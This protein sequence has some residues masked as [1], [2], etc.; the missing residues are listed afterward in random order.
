MAYGKAIV[1]T[2]VAFEG[3]DTSLGLISESTA[4]GFAEQTL[5][6]IRDDNYR[7][8]QEKIA[9]RSFEHQHSYKSLVKKINDEILYDMA[10]EQ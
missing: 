6:L 10:S 2:P 7:K 9:A 5:N 8:N 1:G 4:E 3:I